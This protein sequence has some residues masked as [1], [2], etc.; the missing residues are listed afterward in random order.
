[1]TPLR[2]PSRNKW[3][4]RK[5]HLDGFT[6]DSQAE[7]RRYEELRLLEMAGEIHDLKVHPRFELLPRDKVLGLRAV[8]YTADFQYTEGG[9]V[10]V[11]DVKGGS[12][13]ITEAFKLRRQLFLRRYRGVEFRI[14]KM[15][16]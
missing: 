6:F 5:V 1:M 13:T 2:L 14:V 16:R 9:R 3:N 10:I 8:H 4:A 12:A 7:A 11:E 15:R